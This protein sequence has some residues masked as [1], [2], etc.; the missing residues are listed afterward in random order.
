MKS[1]EM[2]DAMEDIALSTMMK[3]AKAAKKRLFSE[4][5]SAVAPMISGG[6]FSEADA[7]YAFSQALSDISVKK[8]IAA[9]IDRFS[10]FMRDDMLDK[11]AERWKIWRKS[12]EAI[13]PA[14]VTENAEKGDFTIDI[15]GET[16]DCLAAIDLRLG[17]SYAEQK[18]AMLESYVDS[19]GKYLGDYA[20]KVGDIVVEGVLS[21]Y[22]AKDIARMLSADPKADPT[23]KAELSARNLSASAVSGLSKKMTTDLGIRRYRWLTSEDSRVRPSHRLLEG[24]IFY[25]DE[26]AQGLMVQPDV[27]GLNPGEGYLCRCTYEMVDDD[28]DEIFD[29][30][31][32]IAPADAETAPE[33]DSRGDIE[34]VTDTGEARTKA[35]DKE[36]F[37]AF[38][39]AFSDVKRKLEDDGEKV[40]FSQYQDID[41]DQLAVL[42]TVAGRL[43]FEASYEAFFRKSASLVQAQAENLFHEYGHAVDYLAGLK[44]ISDS[45]DLY[46]AKAA[47]EWQAFLNRLRDDYGAPQLTVKKGLQ[48]FDIVDADGVGSFDFS[49]SAAAVDMSVSLIKYF[50]ELSRYK[51]LEDFLKETRTYGEMPKIED[52]GGKQLKT[53]I[54]W[55]SP[56]DEARYYAA[57][58]EW[59]KAQDE[60]FEKYGEDPTY[61]ALHEA[62]IAYKDAVGAFSDHIDATFYGGLTMI[63]GSHG[64][65]Y[66]KR[67]SSLKAAELYAEVFKNSMYPESPDIALIAQELPHIKDLADYWMAK[68]KN[69]PYSVRVAYAAVEDEYAQY[70]DIDSFNARYKP[71]Y[72]LIT[73]YK[74]KT[75]TYTIKRS[76]GSEIED[77]V[78]SYDQQ[79]DAAA[80]YYDVKTFDMSL[81]RKGVK[82]LIDAPDNALLW[83]TTD[84]AEA[85]IAS[86][87]KS[88]LLMKTQPKSGF[89]LYVKKDAL[90]VD[91]DS[92][93]KDFKASADTPTLA[94]YAQQ[95]GYDAI[96][97]GTSLTIVNEDIV[98]GKKRIKESMLSAVMPVSKSFSAGEVEIPKA[99][100]PASTSDTAEAAPKPAKPA[101]P[102]A[103]QIA[104]EEKAKTA[105]KMKLSDMVVFGAAHGKI[106]EVKAALARG[107]RGDT[108]KS[109][110]LY[111]AVKNRHLEI[112]KLLIVAGA[113]ANGDKIQKRLPLAEAFENRDIEMIKILLDAGASKDAESIVRRAAKKAAAE[114]AEIAKLLGIDGDEEA[115]K[116]AERKAKIAAMLG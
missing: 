11:L 15:Y 59:Y 30:L 44:R 89:E 42:T 94:I 4:Y 62:S 3:I 5:N 80:R 43:T 108:Q 116:A 73:T 63:D 9:L 57:R 105:S 32:D 19:V 93:V 70:E 69:A 65:A 49:K 68:T 13:K 10:S 21:G 31:A 7:R 22:G 46:Q 26:G 101:A 84:G 66:W 27:Q 53:K 37:A 104:A 23:R 88:S 98:L 12:R 109:L 2:L 48:G 54:K 77:F 81:K 75:S 16:K 33:V 102:T 51:P 113:D 67:D 110:G 61:I 52:Y 106:E 41:A 14:A 29:S 38:D 17:K 87:S 103:E 91:Y 78:M 39:K 47:E 115:K 40:D 100:A 25:W 56:D 50:R 99:K 95:Q 36:A 28:L 60:W 74:P 107:V 55:K 96:R 76:D 86:T 24:Q 111:F 34:T 72:E 114:N 92:L 112:A 45:S 1:Y 79:L 97:H 20:E 58:D 64:E 71:L 8:E 90:V 85:Q 82:N 18:R 6:S 83:Y 35:T